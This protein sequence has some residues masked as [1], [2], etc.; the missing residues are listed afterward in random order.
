VDIAPAVVIIVGVVLVIALIFVGFN[1]VKPESLSLK[2]RWNS[3][4]F[5]MKRSVVQIADVEPGDDPKDH[6]KDQAA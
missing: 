2:V 6:R 3:L 1:W 4:E 5:E